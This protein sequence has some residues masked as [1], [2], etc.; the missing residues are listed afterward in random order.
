[1]RGLILFAALIAVVFLVA[2]VSARP[3]ACA[4][5]ACSIGGASVVAKVKAIAKAKVK[6]PEIAPLA[7]PGGLTVIEEA[8]A[9]SANVKERRRPLRN[10][11]DRLTPRR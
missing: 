9:E 11:L 10:I 4:N 7:A 2:D 1:M 5:G 3:S 8:T 6:A